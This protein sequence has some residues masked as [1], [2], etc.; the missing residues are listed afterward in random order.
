MYVLDSTSRVDK[1]TKQTNKNQELKIF[2]KRRST[3]IDE[4]QGPL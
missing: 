3:V 2:F 4:A 1:M